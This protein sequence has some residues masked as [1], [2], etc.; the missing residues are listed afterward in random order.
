MIAACHL[1]VAAAEETAATAATIDLH[2]T[3]RVKRRGNFAELALACLSAKQGCVESV[4]LEE[5]D[6][7]VWCCSAV[8]ITPLWLFRSRVFHIG[9][10]SHDHSNASNGPY[11]WTANSLCVGKAAMG[12][13]RP[14]AT[15][16]LLFG[17]NGDVLGHHGSIPDGHHDSCRLLRHTGGF[18]CAASL[19]LGPHAPLTWSSSLMSL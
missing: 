2:I 18:Q 6:S 15:K 9:F 13:V 4:V 3:G 19:L 8:S 5:V 14:G 17:E 1:K 10:C 11:G 7:I 16:P 12:S